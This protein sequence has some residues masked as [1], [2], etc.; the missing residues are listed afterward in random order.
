MIK[1]SHDRVIYS[2]GK[3]NQIALWANP[4]DILEIETQNWFSSQRDYAKE[5][6]EAENGIPIN[7]A[8][9]PI[10]IKGATRGDILKIDILAIELIE[11]GLMF[12]FP[13]SGLLGTEINNIHTKLIS[14]N[15]GYA[16]FNEHIRIPL[17]PMIG[18][19]GTSPDDNIPCYLPGRHGGNMDNQHICAGSSVYLPVYSDG[20][21]FAVGD[22]HGVMGDGEV[23]EWGL[24]TSGKV[25][26]Q[27]Q[28]IK[29]KQLEW[30]V[31]ETA[32]DYYII[33]SL[34]NLDNTIHEAIRH[35]V[36]LIQK[37]SGLSL[38]DASSLASLIANVE[39]CQVTN[40][41][42]TVRIRFSKDVDGI[43]LLEYLCG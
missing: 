39:I 37:A 23:S 3:K 32:T 22:L 33:V 15:D 41:I 1:L 29:N 27:T 25:I 7:P 6:A 30:P 18:V 43:N 9:G 31:L 28:L 10:G 8:T 12:S 36:Q 20:G 19:V 24:E 26:V 34:E 14:M 5:L 2:M 11:K 42:K 21:G 35:S 38:E 4:G 13:G 17:K 16:Q 40:P